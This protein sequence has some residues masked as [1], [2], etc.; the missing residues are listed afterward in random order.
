MKEYVLDEKDNKI[1]TVLQ[2]DSRK[3]IR[4]IAK[5]TGIRP[6]T[7][8]KRLKQLKEEGIIQ[9]FTLKLDNEKIGE[10]FIVF[11]LI[12]G[13]SDKYIDKKLLE[14]A[15]VQEVHGITGEYDLLM[16]LKFKDLGQFNKFIVEFR[17][18]YSAFIKKTITMVQTVKLKD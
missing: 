16:K 15:H 5:L 2:E 18:K 9:K 13:S 10:N 1:L 6:S 3:S 12:S 8:H 14:N 7:V 4:Y 17:A 11:M